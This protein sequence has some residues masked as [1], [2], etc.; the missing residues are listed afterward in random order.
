MYGSRGVSAGRNETSAC[1]QQACQAALLLY[2]PIGRPRLVL[3]TQT[4]RNTGARRDYSTGIGRR[5]RDHR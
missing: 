4:L 2:A 1:L 3:I 5:S